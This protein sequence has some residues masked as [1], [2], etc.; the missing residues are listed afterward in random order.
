[1]LNVQRFMLSSA[2]KKGEGNTF[3]LQYKSYINVNPLSRHYVTL[4]QLK[5]ILS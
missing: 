3:L 5:N 4:Q 2:S 1:V